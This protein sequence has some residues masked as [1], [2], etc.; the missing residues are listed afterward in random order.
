MRRIVATLAYFPCL[1]FALDVQCNAVKSLYQSNDCCDNPDG[2][3]SVDGCGPDVTLP[4]LSEL[5]LANRYYDY[6]DL[7]WGAMD[8]D[9]TPSFTQTAN[10][11]VNELF[12][13]E[14]PQ[15]YD[16][17]HTALYTTTTRHVIVCKQLKSWGLN[18]EHVRGALERYYNWLGKNGIGYVNPMWYARNHPDAPHIF[19]EDANGTLVPADTRVDSSWLYAKYTLESGGDNPPVGPNISKAEG[20]DVEIYLK[21]PYVAQNGFPSTCDVIVY[22]ANGWMTGTGLSSAYPQVVVH[23]L[24]VSTSPL[25]GNH[26]QVGE[27]G[28]VHIQMTD[29]LAQR[30]DT[31]RVAQI[32][33]ISPDSIERRVSVSLHLASV[34]IDRSKQTMVRVDGPKANAMLQELDTF[35]DLTFHTSVN[36]VTEI[37]GTRVPARNVRDLARFPAYYNGFQFELFGKGFP[38]GAMY[39]FWSLNG[40]YDNGFVSMPIIMSRFSDNLHTTTEEYNA[41]AAIYHN[42]MNSAIAD[43]YGRSGGVRPTDKIML[44][45]DIMVHEGMHDIQMSTYMAVMGLSRCKRSDDITAEKRRRHST[46]SRRLEEDDHDHPHAPGYF[47]GWGSE[48]TAIYT[49]MM[50]DN[51]MGDLMFQYR[52][53][54]YAQWIDGITSG[55]PL[56][57]GRYFFTRGD[58]QSWGM[59]V[60]LGSKFDTILTSG[61]FAGD[62]KRVMFS[63]LHRRLRRVDKQ[64]M[65]NLGQEVALLSS[66]QSNDLT[67]DLLSRPGIPEFLATIEPTKVLDEVVRAAS[68]EAHG[69]ETTLAAL[70]HPLVVGTV[71]MA[72]PSTAP[73]GLCDTHPLYCFDDEVPF[74]V[75]YA[76]KTPEP[77][78]SDFLQIAE[79]AFTTDN[80]PFPDGRLD[81]TWVAYENQ[82]N[83]QQGRVMEEI[84]SGARSPNLL[85]HVASLVTGN[86]TPGESYTV[87]MPLKELSA[88]CFGI[89]RGLELIGTDEE[90]TSGAGLT[91][92][93][94]P[95]GERTIVSVPETQF[96]YTVTCDGACPHPEHLHASIFARSHT[97]FEGTLGQ[98]ISIGTPVVVHEYSSMPNVAMYCISNAVGGDASLHVTVTAPAAL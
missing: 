44:N 76:K 85:T 14:V 67:D 80:N 26:V 72:N 37:T 97:S 48:A 63:H 61:P 89:N 18:T 30:Y 24:P 68:L 21:F 88:Y 84:I 23:S 8:Y 12:A 96:T 39:H 55:V 27:D 45:P 25:A 11:E 98:S 6:Q 87:S 73:A 56:K 77:P 5:G 57:G 65:Q 7:S 20:F 59:Y 91:Y 41:G 54:R 90:D 9:W 13:V 93:N 2:S 29:A 16:A 35:A 3:F 32:L 58:Y 42:N 22:Y 95:A 86:F 46:T 81:P 10:M 34:H 50:T 15:F 52:G 53:P 64:I 75:V 1:T 51:R 60:F 71:L 78:F 38:H 92:P 49:E 4:A 28:K 82:Y 62:K 17:N 79:Q 66:Y 19:K 31:A 74:D 40:M 36:G 33:G 94:P 83:W 69:T 47:T 70:F 43:S